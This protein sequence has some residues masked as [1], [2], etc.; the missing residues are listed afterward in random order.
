MAGPAGSSI[1]V[2]VGRELSVIGKAHSGTP[3]SNRE[4]LFFEEK[5]I[6]GATILAIQ[7]HCG[8]GLSN[9]SIIHLLPH[10]PRATIGP[11]THTSD[12]REKKTK[13]TTIN[14]PYPHEIN[15]HCIAITCTFP[16]HGRKSLQ[17][18]LRFRWCFADSAACAVRSR[19]ATPQLLEALVV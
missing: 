18:R 6:S 3:P 2:N 15:T 16:A 11:S 10:R 14:N 4:M 8:P 7:L 19:E 9:V 12:R 1:A 13:H 5:W 17:K